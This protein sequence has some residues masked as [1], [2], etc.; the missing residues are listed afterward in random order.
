MKLLFSFFFKYVL[1]FRAISFIRSVSVLCILGFMVSLS[2]FIIVI[3]VMSGFGVSIRKKLLQ[4]EP[5]LVVSHPAT[6]KTQTQNL[7]PVISPILNKPELQSQTQAVRFF[8]TQDVILQTSSGLFS[9]AIGKGYLPND[10]QQIVSS[11]E[12][13]YFQDVNPSV[14]WDSFQ[15]PS[16]ITD[17]QQNSYEKIYI[18]SALAHQLQLQIGDI[19]FLFPAENL[20]LPLT[21]VTPPKKVQVHSILYSTESSHLSKNLLYEFNSIASLKNTSSLSNGVEIFLHDADQYS[22][23]KQS[24]ASLPVIVESWKDRNSSLFFA[25]KIE[26]WLMIVFLLLATCISS[27]SMV[28]MIRLLLTQKKQDIGILMAMGW[29]IQK[30]RKLFVGISLMMSFIGAIGGL[31]FGFLICLFLKHN[32]IPILPEIYYNRKIPV[33][34]SPDVFL[35]AG[36][37]S[38][39]LAYIT[40]V[41]PVY[42]Y[43][44]SSSVELL[45]KQV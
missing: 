26:K 39:I 6:S 30:I 17:T 42:S 29:S 18:G 38:L 36:L 20:L 11:F 3:N 9:G 35:M 5:H 41:V 37:I 14:E 13:N 34:I 25:L 7:L 27:F 28:S 16:S 8:E 4:H 1:S 32:A 45:K 31:V 2:S 21:E 44:L 40:S 23:Y 22:L 33:E 19:A 43:T 10:L 12:K 24:L 15:K